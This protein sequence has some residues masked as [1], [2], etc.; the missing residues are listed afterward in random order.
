VLAGKAAGATA[1]AAQW[2]KA[3]ERSAH[4]TMAEIENRPLNVEDNVDKR[5]KLQITDPFSEEH[6]K[7]LANTKREEA[8]KGVLSQ[9][10]PGV[11]WSNR[12][13]HVFLNKLRAESYDGLIHQLEKMTGRKAN[14]HEL[15][16]LAHYVNVATGRGNFGNLATSLEVL[17]KLMWS[18]RL[19]ASRLQ[20]LLL[21]P[22][23][24]DARGGLAPA[25]RTLVVGE[26]LRSGAGLG[27]ALSLA[28]MAGAKIELDRRSKDF[29]KV[30]IGNTRLDLMAGLQQPFVLANQLWT[31]KQKTQRGKVLPIRGKVPYGA[32]TAREL[33][34][35]FALSKATPAIGVGLNIASGQT[36][37]GQP[38][39]P[40]NEALTAFLPLSPSDIQDAAQAE[41][42]PNEIALSLLALGGAGVG[43][44][45]PSSQREK[46][47]FRMKLERRDRALLH[48]DVPQAYR[49][50]RELQRGPF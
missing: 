43:T 7:A 28:A 15:G 13:F 34:S 46:D 17:A 3:G 26:Y 32:P 50:T 30:R 2:G 42:M 6:G 1:R 35:R 45:A 29:G 49:L 8:F 9:K 12:T 24:H 36:T 10:I 47:A 33:V 18:P 23:W 16:I 20:Y 39:T 21:N 5:G 40:L 37:T 22:I 41:G 44:Y 25:A 4:E 48:G 38:T 19:F 11:N 27:L 31:G 14:D